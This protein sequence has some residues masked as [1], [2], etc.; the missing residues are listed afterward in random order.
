MSFSLADFFPKYPNI[1]KSPYP[2][3]NSYEDVDFNQAIYSK[4]EFLELKL[5]KTEVKSPSE[6]LFKHQRII[7]TYT[8][9]HTPYDGIV[10]VHE[11]GSGKTLS[12]LG[13]IEQI[14]NENAGYKGALIITRNPRIL[15]NIKKEL[16]DKFKQYSPEEYESRV[17]TEDE[18][19]RRIN[20]L[21]GKYYTFNSF[22]EIQKTLSSMS[23]AEIVKTYSN[24]I[25]GIDEVHN[26]RQYEERK[27]TGGKE[28]SIQYN[29][30]HRLMHLVK[31]CKKIIMSGTP[32]RDHPNEIAPVLNLILPL[33]KQLPVG[34]QFNEM[35][36]YERDGVNYVKE[37]MKDDLK[38][39]MKGRVSFLK[40]TVDVETQYVG[41]PIGDLKYTPVVPSYM[42]DFQTEFYNQSYKKDT[43]GKDIDDENI[44]EV[45]DDTEDGGTG[46]YSNS[47][48]A[49][50][51]VFPDGSYGL[52]GFKKYITKSESTTLSGTK[53]KVV[54]SFRLSR[55]FEKLLRGSTVE[56][57]ITNIRKY[58]ALYANIIESILST[59]DKLHFIYGSRV[60]GSGN[61]LLGCLLDLVGYGRARGMEKTPALRYFVISSQTSS[62][63]T[64]E[65]IIK[66]FSSPNNM[67]GKFIN[68]IIGSKIISE[69]LTIKNV[70]EIHIVTPHWNYSELS[71]AIA[72]GIRLRAHE[73]LIK[74]GQEPIIRVYQH[75][76]IPATGI[77][78]DLKRYELS[79]KKD[80]AMKDVERLIKESAFDCAL[81]YDRNNISTEDGTRNCEYQDCNYRCDGIDDMD[82][83]PDYSTYNLYYSS[84]NVGTIITRIM[85]LFRKRFCYTI[86]NLLKIIKDET[87]FNIFTAINK[88]IYENREVIN[89][90]GFVSYLREQNDLLF[91]VESLSSIP[92]YY[93]SNYA[94]HPAVSD[95]LSY[96]GA[97]NNLL[98]SKISSDTRNIARYI[99]ELPVNIQIAFIEN[100]IISRNNNEL[101][102]VGEAVL[103]HYH[104]DDEDDDYRFQ[105][106][107]YCL[108][109]GVWE[110]CQNDEPE[111]VIE[112]DEPEID[113]E[114]ENPYG[115]SGT[116]ADDDFCIKKHMNDEDI[117]DPRYRS[118]GR[119]CPKSWHIDE[120]VNIAIKLQVQ[121]KDSN[122]KFSGITTMTRARVLESLKLTKLK[123]MIE[124]LKS[125]S[126]DD[127]R[128]A[129]YFSSSKIIGCNAIRKW[130]EE[131]DLLEYN[132]MC[133][134]KG[135]KK[136]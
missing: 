132:S 3:M 116:Y 108:I 64:T 67:N 127:L 40:S 25:I 75:V 115:Y 80:I 50:L 125:H 48:Q 88:I 16:A 90:F 106:K 8:S 44:I 107:K 60:S 61:I 105:G 122:K 130:F 15:R 131:N 81:T 57:T 111:I 37:D 11:M 47:Q 133:G 104:V 10:L 128:R 33:D 39:Y 41:R 82:P 32:M 109:E 84:G 74:G 92:Q 93:P 27:K 117:K 70:Q 51:F 6:R 14:K 66:F 21:V 72:R 100:A 83:Q 42:S 30:I 45:E 62:D 7:S 2:V 22:D 53:K 118:T 94:Q 24:M 52:K 85:E 136:K 103:N 49:T 54:S 56:E 55:E 134:V 12:L 19:I 17:L 13:S 9:S 91:L 120:L 96:D 121:Y 97:F 69:G 1:K 119:A 110:E 59:P 99:T 89:P 135:A 43:A 124:E 58:S 129:L 38:Q 126:D 46:V 36:L 77:S 123:K 26:L 87:T 71:Q 73:D 34:K 95:E 18:T 63:K 68:V 76:D 98:I 20:K 29:Q 112:E 78:I 79:E 86:E 102:E 31:G 35:Y 23:D 4:K 65:N 113:I 114:I 101:N 28:K 5:A